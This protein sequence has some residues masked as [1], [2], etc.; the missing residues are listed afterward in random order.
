MLTRFRTLAAGALVLLSLAGC[1]SL[2]EPYFPAPAKRPVLAPA[3]PAPPAPAVR[4]ERK[5]PPVASTANGTPA[6]SKLI[7]L[8]PADIPPDQ[9]QG[10]LT[11]SQSL[12]DTAS[13]HSDL[14][15]RMRA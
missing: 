5:P 4:T 6:A 2:T 12:S 14:M 9:L 3:K 8:P 11:T 7:R 13:T 15:D 10:R 1:A